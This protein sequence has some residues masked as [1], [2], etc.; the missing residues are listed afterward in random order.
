[1]AGGGGRQK[2]EYAEGG[3]VRAGEA[4]EVESLSFSA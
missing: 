4:V 3:K 2:K 1:M